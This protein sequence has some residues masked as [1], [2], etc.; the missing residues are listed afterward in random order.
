[1]S[2]CIAN[3]FESKLDEI[4]QH[5]NSEL[6]KV[7]TELQTSKETLHLNMIHFNGQM[8]NVS[9]Y[10]DTAL[11]KVQTELKESKEILELKTDHFDEEMKN[12]K[13]ALQST[14]KSLV[15]L[16]RENALL[17]EHLESAS[18]NLVNI[19]SQFQTAAQ[20]SSHEAIFFDYGLKNVM[21]STGLEIVKFDVPRAVSPKKSTMNQLG[22]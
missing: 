13:S 7:K 20:P 10:F 11:K 8:K 12:V 19:S 4:T 15:E 17:K 9:S 14:Q 16:Q 1:M 18:K 21:T 2:D 3:D 6:R 5:F 22:K